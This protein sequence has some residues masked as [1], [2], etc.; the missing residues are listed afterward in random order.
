M[1]TF[2]LGSVAPLI[3]VVYRF[4]LASL[5]LFVYCFVKQKRFDFSKFDHF[6]ILL[7]GLLLFGFSYWLTYI[8]ITKINSAL[9]AILRTSII[10]FNVVFARIFL[11]DKIK[12]E[13][14][15]GATI[16]TLNRKQYVEL[17][18]KMPFKTD[19]CGNVI[20]QTFA[21]KSAANEGAGI[22]ILLPYP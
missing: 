13:V 19:R 20:Y 12:T 16:G 9:A 8:V 11:G 3:S 2:Q 1:I 10:Y 17:S 6:L 5:I 22:F 15:T 14:L 18:L 21:V 4:S 7:Q